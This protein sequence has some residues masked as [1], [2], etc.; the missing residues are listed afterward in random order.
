MDRNVLKPDGRFVE[1]IQKDKDMDFYEIQFNVII[2]KNNHFF[3]KLVFVYL[4][5]ILILPLSLRY[6]YARRFEKQVNY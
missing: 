6:L 4:R 1:K 5:K 2:K 3:E